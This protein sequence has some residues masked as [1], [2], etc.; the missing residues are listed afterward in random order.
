MK[1][2]SMSKWTNWLR[3]KQGHKTL[4]AKNNLK[5]LGVTLK[6]PVRDFKSLRKKMMKISEDGNYFHDHE[7]I[8]L[9][10]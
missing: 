6:K 9:T 1:S 4:L 7:S 3:G 10:W 5:Y 8:H 2:P